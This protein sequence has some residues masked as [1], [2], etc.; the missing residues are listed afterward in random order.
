M[1]TT[2][3]SMPV[4]EDTP[5]PPYPANAYSI[6]QNYPG[7]FIATMNIDGNAYRLYFG[8]R[9]NNGMLLLPGREKTRGA[10]L[11]MHTI[12]MHRLWNEGWL[13][14]SKSSVISIVY[15][16]GKVNIY[17][18]SGETEKPYGR[19]YEPNSG[20]QIASCYSD[21]G[22]WEGIMFYQLQ[23]VKAYLPRPSHA[24]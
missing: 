11:Y 16:S 2:T 4:L 21:N 7:K 1:P 15:P 3:P 14:I 12:W 18:V 8:V 5:Y 9:G 19:Y 10:A 17:I 22:K 6:N 13:Q 20:Y 24:K 23:L